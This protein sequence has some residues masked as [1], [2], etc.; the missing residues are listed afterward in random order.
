[1]FLNIG[2]VPFF[3]TQFRAT[4][5]ELLPLTSANS[6][7]ASAIPSSRGPYFFSFRRS[8]SLSNSAS[9]S[10][11]SKFFLLNFRVRS[12]APRTDQGVIVKPNPC[13]IGRSSRSGVRWIRLYSI[14][15]AMKGVQFLS[16]ARVFAWETTQA[17][18]SDT[19]IYNTFP[20]RISASTP[21]DFLDRG[22][23]IPHVNPEQID[24]IGLQ[25]LQ[26]GFDG[27]DHALA[28]V[29]SAVGVI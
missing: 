10:R 15:S 7:T 16:S 8:A 9:R 1:M 26:A 6:A 18:W 4:C 11:G 19:P 25:P 13:A 2:M 14:C 12:P 24:V 28:T 22:Y 23:R 27:L 17:G 21:H 3:R 20:E 29:S 5:A